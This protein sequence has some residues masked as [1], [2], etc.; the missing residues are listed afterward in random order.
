MKCNLKYLL[1]IYCSLFIFNNRLNAQSK[2][3]QDHITKG[4][5]LKENKDYKPAIDEFNKAIKLENDNGMTYWERAVCYENIED[6]KNALC[7]I[8]RA[9]GYLKGNKE[10]LYKLY[11][12]KGFYEYELHDYKDANADFTNSL[13]IN[14]KYSKVYYYRALS[15]KDNKEYQLSIKD[16]NKALE[17]YA[18]SKESLPSIYNLRGIAEDYLDDFKSSIEDFSK[19]IELNPK[20]ARAI[21]NRADVY[22]ETGDYKSAL[23]DYNSAMPFYEKDKITLASL[24]QK[25][26]K[27]DYMETHYKDAIINHTKAI[28]LEPK[29]GLAYWN[30]GASYYHNDQI[31]EALADFKMAI[32]LYAND[33][34]KLA[35]IHEL[36]GEMYQSVKDNSRA[37]DEY[38]LAL[39][40]NPKSGLA[41]YQKGVCFYN[42]KDYKSS[43]NEFSSSISL[44]EKDTMNL[45]NCYN[46]RG[47]VK[48]QMDDYKGAIED[49]TNAIAIRPKYGNAIWNRGDAYQFDND[50]KHAI[51]D[52]TTSLAYYQN[53]SA[54]LA[55]IYC[56]R[57][58]T[59]IKA[60]TY[61][62]AIEDC[63]IALKFKPDYAAPYSNKG[64]AMKDSGLFKP[65]IEEY[66]KAIKLYDNN[67]EKIA[68]MYEYMGYCHN[69][70]SEYKQGIE[71]FNHA[72][73]I[74]PKYGLAFWNRGYSYYKL[75]DY[76]AAI[77][78][79]IYSIPLYE[80][81]SN[82]IANIHKDIGIVYDKMKD[83]KAAIEEHTK[84]LQFNPRYGRAY[85]ERGAS[86]SHNKEYKLSI[87]DF[88]A[89]NLLY[90]DDSSEI[91][92]GYDWIGHGYYKMMDYPRA[93]ENYNK[94]L[95]YK[96]D[97]EQSLW[98]RANTYFEDA[99]FQ[100]SI[101]EYDKLIKIK[102]D[103]EDL[104]SLHSWKF[105]A[106]YD[107]K[108]YDKAL[109]EANIVLKLSEKEFSYFYRRG[110]AL[111]RLNRKEEAVKDFDKVMTMDTT[112][113][114]TFYIYALYYKGERDSAIT[115]FKRKTDDETDT[116]EKTSFTNSLARLYSMNNQPKEA[117]ECLKK[118]IE[119]G[120]PLR[121]VYYEH[122]IA[123]FG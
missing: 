88:T 6:Y 41:H 75:K 40:M 43:I 16:C 47:Y 48:Y 25:I 100:K 51:E 76:K 73:S 118:S 8:D 80:N 27:C 11:F 113:K 18:D 111:L 63:D 83:Y 39:E 12:D 101:E 38:N 64:T 22:K 3:V 77:S 96:P 28:T 84:A 29:Y 117:I 52:Y 45:S 58:N 116:I 34:I 85:H 54:S 98:N 35:A 33:S 21:T 4:K 72:I 53:D 120:Y 15:Y 86:H 49:Y 109:E 13:D 69:Q 91:A 23:A 97:Y 82:T 61:L 57:A 71:E 95:S 106:Y 60:K 9:I 66:K 87:E 105:N 79:Y 104:A 67:N 112:K 78:D 50:Y 7:D 37:I 89:S 68:Q 26:G 59:K 81:D 123:S 110:K 30:R 122:S 14:P 36:V 2:D 99:Y 5:K 1:L 55:Y 92:Y 31:K 20:F 103:T 62:S 10:W 19:A 93:L 119:G 114:T 108:Q 70:I 102:K 46:Y 24:Y 115:L 121:S 65:A 56:S 32:S 94:A 74:A 42:K 44:Y 17:I 90:K 107:D